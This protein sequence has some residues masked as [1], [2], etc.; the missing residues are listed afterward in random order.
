MVDKSNSEEISKTDPIICLK[1]IAVAYQSNVALFDVNLDIYSNDFIGICGPNGSGKSTLIKAIVG[2][3]KPFRGFVKVFGEDI[4]KG[5]TGNLKAKIGYLPQKVQIERN[6][7][8]LVKDI[9]AMGLYSQIGLFRDLSKNDITKVNNSLEK[10]GM[11]NFV[12]RPI[13][14]LS[15]GQQQKVMIARGIVNNP[16]ILLLD[17]PFTSLDL[18]VE[19]NFMSL[20]KKIHDESH[21]TIIMVSH[22][23]NFIKKYCNRAICMD[24]KIIWDGNPLQKDF[25][26]IIKDFFFT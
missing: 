12:N 23:I 14:H 26:K 16:K 3:V 19:Q 1:D 21:V 22:N 13:G 24:R 15:G 20:I 7:P 8:A 17:E 4:N 11:L 10:I 5:N 6:F 25:D 18:K 2:A 9:V